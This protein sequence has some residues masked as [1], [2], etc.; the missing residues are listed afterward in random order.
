MIEVIDNIGYKGNKPNF[1]RDNMT[2]EQM[3]SATTDTVELGHVVYCTTAGYQGH[4]TFKSSSGDFD[5]RWT[6]VPTRQDYND[7]VARVAE[8]IF[9]M[10]FDPA[11]G[12]VYAL[13]DNDN[14]NFIDAGIDPITGTVYIDYNYDY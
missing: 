5:A 10:G 1:E 6:K 7:L 4:Y 13:V 9:G 14:F 12:D 11:T 2:Y 8:N 3:L